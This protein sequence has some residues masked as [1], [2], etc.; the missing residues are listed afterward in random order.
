MRPIDQLQFFSLE[1]VYLT[2]Y[3]IKIEKRKMIKLSSLQLL[4]KVNRR[5]L[6]EN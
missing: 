4:R 2:R 5:K 6:Y 1:L 3:V